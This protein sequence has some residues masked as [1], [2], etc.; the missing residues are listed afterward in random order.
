MRSTPTWVAGCL[1]AL[2]LG[3]ATAQTPAPSA[4]LLRQAFDETEQGWAAMG[5]NARATLVRDAANVKLGT[6][7]LKLD[8]QVAKGEMNGVMAMVTE[9][10]PARAKSVRFWVKA[11]YNAS[12]GLMVQE[13][14]PGGRYAATFY[15]PAGKWQEV[16]IA[17]SDMVLSDGKDDPKD[18]D[19]KLSV[20]QIAGYG[21]VDMSQMFVQADNADL[22]RLLNLKSGPH[23]LYLDEFVVSAEAPVG[24]AAPAGQ[25]MIDSYAR[26]QIGW[27]VVGQADASM[28]AGKPLD[29]RCL[30]TTY[31]VGAGSLLGLVRAVR[32]GTLAGMKRISFSMAATR[33]TRLLVQ[34]EE[35]G[36]GKYNAQV[37]ATGGSAVQSI[38]L[39]FAGFTA[40]DDSKDTNGTLDIP[41]IKSI[42][43][44]DMSGVMG[45]LEQDNTLWIGTIKAQG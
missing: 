5:P 8:Y 34:V 20:D 27:M 38:D 4:A 3:T 33:A 18:T 15:V 17:L 37:E 22:L 30:K 40:G 26:P 29:V 42:A 28:A 35:T 23:T 44:I 1:T 7:A 39:P 10:I 16:E 11:D 32:P 41:L 43:I 21:I 2:I 45:G 36:G 19:G 25:A 31:K 12:L 14:E 9:P 6:G 13:R 24:A